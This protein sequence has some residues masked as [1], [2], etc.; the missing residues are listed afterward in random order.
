[1]FL[2]NDAFATMSGDSKTY[3]YCSKVYVYFM[4]ISFLIFHNVFYLNVT[5]VR[6]AIIVS[7]PFVTYL[8]FCVRF[9]I[10]SIIKF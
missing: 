1:M 6:I 3:Y 9:A 4:L 5:V 8:T 10:F 7:V 2:R